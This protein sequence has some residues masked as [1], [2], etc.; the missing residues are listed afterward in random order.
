MEKLKEKTRESLLAVLPITAIVLLISILI[1]PMDTGVVTL[2]L[3]GAFMLVI[4]MGLFQ[5]GA[6]MTMMPLGEGIGSHFSKTR[7]LWLIIIITFVVGVVITI[8]EPDLQVLAHQ[9]AS[10]PNNVLILTVSVGVGLMLVLAVLRILFRISLSRILLILYGILIVVSFVAPD[11]FVAVSFDSGGVT[12]GPITVPFILALGVGLSSLR[13][14]KEAA[15]DSFGLVAICSAGPIVAVLMLGIFYN[16][17]EVTSSLVTITDVSTMQDV[18]R[19]LGQGLPQYIGEV[20]ISMLPV[21]AVFFLF[22]LFSRRFQKRQFRRMIVG[23]LYTYLGLVLFLCGVNVGF[24]PVGSLLG[25]ELVNS[26]WRW[27]LVPIGMVIGYFIIKAEPAVA[28][29]NRQVEDVTDGAIPGTAVNRALSIGTAAAV[30]L[31]LLRVLSGISIY[32]II[33]PGYVI[34]LILTRFVPKI[35][36]GIAFDSGG[37]AS[38]PMTTT[39]LLPLAIGV[40]KAVGGHEMTDAFGVVALVALTP[41]IAVQIMG[42]LFVIKQKKAPN[43]EDD[44]ADES[45]EILDLEEGQDNE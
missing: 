25:S 21:A 33:I 5:L 26:A 16:P 35:F 4:G 34:A 39:F 1:V 18:A 3:S 7:K 30:G 28:V 24:A 6:E 15:E 8:A 20:A 9:V 19:A 2:F 40:C 43:E 17:S 10:I 27:L 23:F 42:V 31:A 13:S 14:D 11:A 41:L 22:Q 29:L 12:T 37:V 44:A 36:V 45:A 38:G 32:W